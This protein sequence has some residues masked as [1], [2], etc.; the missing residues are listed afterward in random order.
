MTALAAG[1]KV[2]RG[3]FLAAARHLPEP[4]AFNK[5]VMIPQGAVNLKMQ[6]G[7]GE[8]APASS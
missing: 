3:L 8:P 4:A 7:T 1:K 6:D 5:V 2:I